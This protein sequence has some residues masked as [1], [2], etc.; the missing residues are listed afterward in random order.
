[1]IQLFNVASNDAIGTISEEQLQFLIDQL[2]EEN[3]NDQ[4]YYISRDTIDLLKEK[5]ADEKLLNLLNTAIGEGRDIDI[6]WER[7]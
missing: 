2:V 4:D 6:R 5:G 1:M 7:S 3:A